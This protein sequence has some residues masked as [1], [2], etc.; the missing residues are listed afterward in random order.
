MKR[1]DFITLLGSAATAWPLA[2]RAQQPSVPTIG[3]L[4]VGSPDAKVQAALRKGLSEMGFVEGRNVAIEYRYAEDQYDRLPALAAE[5]VRRRVAV[6]FTFGGAVAVPA[7]KAATT[8]IPIVFVTGAD[9]VQTGMVASFNRPGGNVTGISSMTTELTA[10]RLG[11]LHEL[12]PA[13]TRIAVLVNP[14]IARTVASVTTYAQTAASAIGQ[15][16]EVFPASTNDEID[17]A[18]ASMVQ[19]RAEALL[20]GTN[21]L[22]TNRRVQLATLATRH[23]LPAVH[24]LREFVEAG[25][26]MSYGSNN[27]DL[28]RQ[29]GIYVGRVLKGEKPDD[30]PIMQPAKFEFVI[31]LQSA[32]ALGIEVSPGL[33]AIADDVIE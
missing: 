29:G 9:P 7:A 24:F 10:K 20:I 15:Q 31:N 21:V 16:I 17:A 25:G 4:D 11:L 5:L 32:R 23:A 3:Y 33:L 26:L 18:F 2:A 19:R 8:T 22:F 30:L 1:R 28:T 14:G 12:L 27:A 13:A 6:I